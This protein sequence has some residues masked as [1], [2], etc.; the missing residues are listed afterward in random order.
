MM[1]LN[2][3]FLIIFIQ[4]FAFS[5]Y[6]IERKDDVNH[7]TVIYVLKN[8]RYHAITKKTKILAHKQR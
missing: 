4:F 5:L 3:L 7:N 2:V 1:K 8:D 6:N